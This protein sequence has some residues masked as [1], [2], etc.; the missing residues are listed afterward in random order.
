MDSL[1]LKVDKWTFKVPKHLLYNENDFWTKIEGNN[2]T[3]G[4][5]DYMQNMVS[6]I[7]YVELPAIGSRIEQFDEAGSFESTKTTLEIISPVT[8]SIQ[9]VNHELEKT[10]DLANTEPYGKGWFLKVALSNFESDKENLI[11]ANNYFEVMK[12]KIKKEHEKL[13]K[14]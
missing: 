1:E 4:I 10:P 6:D 12:K 13:K 5:T 11:D 9:E 3:V 2:A 8:G 7:I 14:K